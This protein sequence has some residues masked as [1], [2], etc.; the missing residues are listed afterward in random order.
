M[1]HAAATPAAAATP[2]HALEAEE[3]VRRFGTDATAGLSPDEAARRLAETGP[4]EL[5]GPPP[6]S[7][8]ARWLA[9]FLQPVTSILVVAAGIA[10]LLGDVADAAL[11]ATILVVDAVIGMAMEERAT[12]AIEALR[13]L[14]APR[15]RGVRGG[16]PW[17]GPSHGVVPGDLIDVVAGDVVPA[18]ARLLEGWG[19]R[20]DESSLTGESGAVGKDP[21]ARVAA[22]ATVG[23][24][25]TL[26]HAGTT[27]AAGR[28]RGIVVATGMGTELGRIAGAVAR[29]FDR[30]TP[31]ER[32][33]ERLGR[34]LVAVCLALVAVIALVEGVRGAPA[35]EVLARALSLAVATVPEGLPAVVTV[36]L[37]V[38][39]GRMAARHVLVR[40]LPAV[41]TLGAVTVLCTD[42]TGTLTTNRMALAAIAAGRGE[43]SSDAGD[44]GVAW[45][46]TAAG[47]PGAD[48]DLE[49][50]LACAAGA[51]APPAAARAG[52][53]R[54]AEGD[55]IDVA[56]SRAAEGA[57]VHPPGEARREIP[58]DPIG[59]SSGVVVRE[60]DGGETEFLK[61]APEA[62]LPRCRYERLD[63][64]VVP[65]SAER[66]R[67]WHALA[68]RMAAGGMRVLALSRRDL[69]TATSATEDGVLSGLAGIADPP[70]DDAPA[71]VSACR[72]AGVRP[73]LITG[74]HPA[75]ALAI[76]RAVGITDGPER[77]VTGDEVDAA[78]DA[79]LGEIV[80]RA[81]V[82]ART[83]A[84]HKTRLV[85]ALK[86]RGEVVA[87][88]GDGVNDAPALR[89]A[90][91]GI[92]MGEG[93]CDVTREAAD[94]VLTD[95]ALGSIVAAI[96]EGRTIDDNVGQ[97][98]GYL[99]ACNGGEVLVMF[100]AAVAGLP[101]PLEPAQILWLNLVT[102]GAPALALG[103]EDHDPEAM[104]EGP[105]PPGERL[106]TTGRWTAILPV[107][108]AVGGVTLAAF[109]GV[110]RV[111]GG[112]ESLP[113]AR[114]TAFAT[115][116]A[117]QLLLAFGS[118]SRRR[119]LFSP[120][121]AGNG[122]LA[123]A[124]VVSTLLQA[125]AMA[126]LPPGARPAAEDWWWVAALAPL[127]LSVL[128]AE[129]AWRRWV[130]RPRRSRPLP[131]GRLRGDT[132][133][134][135]GAAEG[136]AFP[137]EE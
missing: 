35:V 24:R 6:P 30:A 4:N 128:E 52:T 112:A 124:V 14:A 78:D 136:T 83:S 97:V 108:A 66:L 7:R 129:K 58:F 65:L 73:V 11:V 9:F 110:L 22:A 87:M 49:A 84:A 34:V 75:T 10:A 16:A 56:L 50:F 62:I 96:G 17:S 46:P 18:D 117:A 53:D 125:A 79:S 90:D 103:L 92:A 13:G 45:L 69:R 133:A 55:P 23:D 21:Q 31:L 74:D 114:A 70:R 91:V 120:G 104:R 99:L 63:G 109:V 59:R 134:S 5:V 82:F 33:M 57:G 25:K 20:V 107:A 135:P 61:G 122:W 72:A 68:G 64:A 42:K 77:V 44:G 28:G 51:A 60:G 127:P 105:R 116:A 81:D 106:P 43:W 115:I 47:P 29:P 95:D 113:R 76:A 41:E 19:L 119:A 38:G 36:I 2:W 123:V 3:V 48:A 26:V 85:A 137:G 121:R 88:T 12:R 39:V 118:R 54:R 80:G 130:A 131:G 94:M 67:A 100:A 86:R 89:A 37:A 111:D 40:R 27:V 1:D 93:G 98:L 15:A 8:V 132:L 71:A 126:S 32:R 101:A 102:D